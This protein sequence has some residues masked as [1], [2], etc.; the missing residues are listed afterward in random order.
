MKIRIRLAE[1]GVHVSPSNVQPSPKFSLTKVRL[2]VQGKLK[3]RKSKGRLERTGSG[4]ENAYKILK[5]TNLRVVE[6]IRN[7]ITNCSSN[8]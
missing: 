8:K 4:A 5:I 2:F 1:N 7:R 6:A 3:F